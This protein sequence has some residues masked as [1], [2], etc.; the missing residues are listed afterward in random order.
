MRRA[1]R[2]DRNQAEI[3]D[4]LRAMGCSV[5]IIG[6]PLDLL[7][8]VPGKDGAGTTMLFEVKDG[9]K[10]PSGRKHTDLQAEFFKTWRGGPV[11]TVTDVDSALRAARVAA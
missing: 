4:A 10:P 11:A 8:G 7:V 6:L 2:V 5:W 3:V 1:A 9:T